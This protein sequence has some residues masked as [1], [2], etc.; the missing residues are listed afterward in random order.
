MLIWIIDVSWWSM[1]ERG[2]D[3]VWAPHFGVTMGWPV[4]WPG[5]RWVGRGL[6]VG[7]KISSI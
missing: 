3:G 7:G 4:G 6:A 5:L 1:I 2:V